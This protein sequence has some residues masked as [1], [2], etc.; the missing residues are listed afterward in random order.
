MG[1]VKAKIPIE[2]FRGAAWN[3][4]FKALKGDANAAGPGTTLDQQGIIGG[5][6]G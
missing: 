6:W 4:D 1:L 5:P 2:K 3:S